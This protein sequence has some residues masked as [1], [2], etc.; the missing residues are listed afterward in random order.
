MSP[1]LIMA[2]LYDVAHFCSWN[3]YP[4]DMKGYLGIDKAS[5]TNQE[6]WFPYGVNVLYGPRG[7]TRLLSI[8]EN[9]CRYKTRE[10]HEAPRIIARVKKLLAYGA[11]PDIK[12]LNGM[13]PL[14]ICARNGLGVT[15]K[16]L[17]DAGADINQTNK[18]GHSPIYLAAYNNKVDNATVLL[19]NGAKDIDSALQ[20]SAKRGHIDIVKILLNAGANINQSDTDGFS[21]LHH[22]SNNNHFAIIK[23]LVERGV[24]IHNTTVAR[25]PIELAVSNGYLNIVK[26]LYEHG[27]IVTDYAFDMIIT[28]EHIN[29]LQYFKK[30]GVNAPVNSIYLAVR[31]NKPKLINLLSKMGGDLNFIGGV[32]SSPLLLAVIHTSYECIE[33][34]CKVGANITM[35]Y[36]DI[37]SLPIQNLVI[38]GDHKAI[39]ILLDNGVNVNTMMCNM[40]LLHYAIFFMSAHNKGDDKFKTCVKEI[41]KRS[42]DFT[43]LNRYGKDA[44]EYAKDYGFDDIVVA[45]KRAA[46]AGKHKKVSRPHK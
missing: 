23:E 19:K 26:Y 3:G 13:S 30:V 15:M 36:R 17:L 4:Q 18:W 39:Q 6:F 8:C 24:D 20:V 28:K 31:E 25:T 5:W 11:K 32:W 45:I 14:L 22:A 27:A 16:L 41:I 46:L 1:P 12:D 33:T 42:P 9:I 35:P 38:R 40:P 10:I 43:L 7:K 37:R 2:T 34:L 29:I 21:P 44:A